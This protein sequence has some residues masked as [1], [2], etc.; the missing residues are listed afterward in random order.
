MDV[1]EDLISGREDEVRK[2]TIEDDCRLEGR[3]DGY[4]GESARAIGRLV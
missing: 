2:R 4:S 1:E 3:R